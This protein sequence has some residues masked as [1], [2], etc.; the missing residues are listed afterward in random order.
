M[1][2]LVTKTISPKPLATGWAFSLASNKYAK[3]TRPSSSK[4]RSPFKPLSDVD[5]AK[6]GLFPILPN[7]YVK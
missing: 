5:P 1:I 2:D 7:D 6:Y 4:R 3:G